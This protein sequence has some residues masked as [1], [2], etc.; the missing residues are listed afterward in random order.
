MAASTGKP[1]VTDQPDY[2]QTLY[3]PEHGAYAATVIPIAGRQG[4]RVLTQPCPSCARVAG[5]A[6]QARLDA[7]R[8]RVQ[9]QQIQAR[10]ERTG[11]PLRYRNRRFDNYRAKQPHQAQT[12]AA[13]RDY[14]EGFAQRLRAGTSLTLIG[15]IGTGKTH[16]AAATLH[17]LCTQGY[18]GL[19]LTAGQVIRRIQQTYGNG[20]ET[21]EAVYRALLAP[22]LLV[23]DEIGAQRQSADELRILFELL[24]LRYAEVRPVML[25]SNLALGPLGELLGERLIDRLREGGGAIWSCAWD[26]YRARAH[27]DPQLTL[28]ETH[29]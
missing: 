25:I 19:Y 11:L 18:S 15:K 22:D 9:E 28:P 13:V 29:A 4:A 16:L 20:A 24:N 7:E 10:L 14:A 27:E 12:L 2:T 5:Q 23:I 8:I 17:S 1:L 21:E 3:C 6:H 26:S